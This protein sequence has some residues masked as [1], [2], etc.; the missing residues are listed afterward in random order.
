MGEAVHAGTRFPA[1]TLHGADAR[2]VVLA[3]DDTKLAR[4][5]SRAFEHIGLE[6]FIALT[7]DA[8]LSAMR[9]DIPVAAV[10]LDIMIPHPDGIEVCRQI[11]R[12][13]WEGP[14]IVISALDSADVRARVAKAGADVFLPK[15]F[16]LTELL[17]TVAA[18]VD[19]A[20]P[21][22]DS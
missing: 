19:S 20:S 10:V 14:T 15:P 7:G 3:E 8:A 2:R 11:R 6:T 21:P 1:S 5:V 17:T 13:G 4:L 18:R 16:H 12:D 22:T 9:D